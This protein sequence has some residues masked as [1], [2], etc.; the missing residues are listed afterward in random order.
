MNKCPLNS[1]TNTQFAILILLLP[2]HLLKLQC[3][4]HLYKCIYTG[5]LGFED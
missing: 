5:G 4:Q 3:L 2:N 1:G